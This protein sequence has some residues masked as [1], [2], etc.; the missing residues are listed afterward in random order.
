MNSA[1]LVAVSF[2]VPLVCLGLLMTLSWLEDTLDD[3][4]KTPVLSNPHRAILT[5]PAEV[6]ADAV[7]TSPGA[8]PDVPPPVPAT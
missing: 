8:E 3:D 2:M 1:V 5:M 7:Q 6:E 4:M